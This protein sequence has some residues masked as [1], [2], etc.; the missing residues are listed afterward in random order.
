MKTTSSYVPSRTMAPTP[1]QPA[2]RQQVAPPVLPINGLVGQLAARRPQV[3]LPRRLPMDWAFPM[4][5]LIGQ[6]AARQLQVALPGRLPM[7]WPFDCHQGKGN[8]RGQE[9]RLR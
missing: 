2:L 9:E 7:D 4:I 6:L 8:G 3:A 5:G 1:H